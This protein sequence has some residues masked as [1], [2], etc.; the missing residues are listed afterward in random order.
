M[1]AK[2]LL[3]NQPLTIFSPHRL[4]DL[5]A[6]RILSDLSDSRLQ[7]FHLIF[8]D[9]SQVTVGCSSQMNPL[10][11][12]PSLLIS[13]RVPAH[14]CTEILDSLTQPSP[15]LF[16]EPPPDP[17]I[18]MFVDGS[19]KKD[20]DGCQAVAYAV[21]TLQKVLEAQPLPLGTTSQK[22]ELTALTRAL[23]LAR[24]KEPVSTQTLSTLS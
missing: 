22:A 7:Q 18:T 15:N 11:V 16:A 24:N 6:S 23:H 4:S 5:F 9:N 17:D 21:V 12:L 10:S 13:S 19:S 2:K 14:Q 20:P 1:D 3:Q 8:L